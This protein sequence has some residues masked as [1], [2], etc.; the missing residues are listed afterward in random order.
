MPWK[1]PACSEQI[2]HAPE[3][4]AP[5]RGTVYRCH[6][7]RLELILDGPNGKL[8]VMPVLRDTPDTASDRAPRRLPRFKF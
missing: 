8:T 6:I 4:E 2:H 1:C 5:Q 3:Q 7:C